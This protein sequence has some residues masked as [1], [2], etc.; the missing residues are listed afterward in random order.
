MKNSYQRGEVM[1][2]YLLFVIGLIAALALI[3]AG[4]GGEEEGGGDNPGEK[5][6][7]AWKKMN[8]VQALHTEFDMTMNVDGDLTSLGEE[9][10]DLLPMEL[11]VAGSADIDQSDEENIKLDATIELDVAEVIDKLIESSGLASG[12]EEAMGL[13]MISSMFTDLKVRMVDQTLYVEIMGSWYEMGVEDVSGLSDIAPMDVEVDEE[14]ATENAQCV[15]DK[16]TPSRMLKDIKDEGKEDIDGTETTHYQASLDTTAA[17]DLL[18]ELSK[19]CGGEEMSDSDIQEAKDTLEGMV[20]KM[21]MGI[22]IDGDSQVR[23]VTIDVEL[24]MAALSDLAGSAVDEAADTLES[25]TVT[26]SMTAQMSKFGEAVTVEAPEDAMPIEDLF[27]AFGG[28][29]GGGADDLE[30]DGTTTTDGSLDDFDLD[31]EGMDEEDTT[32]DASGT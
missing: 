4:C 24:D 14:E 19:E 28:L 23:K 12:S 21:D 5:I 17:V 11:G 26:I 18:A 1:K 9:F 25:M 2:R 16:L 31:T 20:T 32:T 13:Q 27:G 22:W 8:E 10:A 6:D 29:A 30:E 7:A 3:T 15:Q